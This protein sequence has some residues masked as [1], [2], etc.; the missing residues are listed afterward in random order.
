MQVE[1]FLGDTKWSHIL[2]HVKFCHQ[3]SLGAKLRRNLSFYILDS[4]IAGE[5]LCVCMSSLIY[6]FLDLKILSYYKLSIY[7]HIIE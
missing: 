2:V 7:C 3:M 1:I 4:R 5:T 6:W